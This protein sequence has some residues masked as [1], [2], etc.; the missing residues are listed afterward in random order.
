MPL[1]TFALFSLFTVLN[2]LGLAL[3]APLDG[4]AIGNGSCEQLLERKE[5]YVVIVVCRG[6]H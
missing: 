3:A 2:L 1:T 4:V 5:W 6:P